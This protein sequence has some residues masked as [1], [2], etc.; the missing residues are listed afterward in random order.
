LPR[1]LIHCLS[2][3]ICVR[4]YFFHDI[5]G[6]LLLV[7]KNVRAP[8]E[9]APRQD[10]FRADVYFLQRCFFP[11]AFPWSRWS[12]AAN[13]QSDSVRVFTAAATLERLHHLQRINSRSIPD[14]FPRQFFLE[15]VCRKKIRKKPVASEY[16][17]MG[18]DVATTEL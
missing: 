5:C 2:L 14:F 15:S 7:Y 9:R 4:C 6:S 18:C 10:P 17:R 16:P 11:D 8:D 1:H 3:S 13:L 12:H